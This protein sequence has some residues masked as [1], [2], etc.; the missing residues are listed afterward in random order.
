VFSILNKKIHT[1]IIF[2]Q[3]KYF[4][5]I[6]SLLLLQSSVVECSYDLQIINSDG[7]VYERQTINLQFYIGKQ[8]ENL[9]FFV[10]CL[11]T[12]FLFF[13]FL[14]DTVPAAN[15]DLYCSSL[16]GLICPRTFD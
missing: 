10:C 5:F 7:V 6:F 1:N 15:V 16:P 14:G 4:F 3:N 11:F 2:L 13:L 9:Y 8:D 12:I